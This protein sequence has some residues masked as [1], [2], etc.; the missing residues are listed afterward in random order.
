LSER[1]TTMASMASR[2]WKTANTVAVWVYRRTGGRVGGSARGCPVLL[3][4]V[5]GRT[6]G[7]PHTVPVGY[8]LRDGSYYLAASAG[9]SP[10][11]PQWIRNLRRTST[12]TIQVGRHTHPASVEVLR[13]ADRDTA[14]NDVIVA[15][16][17]FFA[18]YET[19]S[20]RRIAVAR[21]TPT[22]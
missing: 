1:G 5:P 9:G 18:D 2:L 20:G 11:E 6:S 22:G 16:H 17:P 3:L 15:A 4:T 7:R 21:V 12:A 8:V 19:K 14:W 13:G 10:S